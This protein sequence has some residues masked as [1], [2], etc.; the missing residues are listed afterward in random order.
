MTCEMNPTEIRNGHLR[1][2][3]SLD[4]SSFELHCGIAFWFILVIGEVKYHLYVKRQT[5]IC[6]T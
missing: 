4:L 2:C 1:L 6:T 3:V 5:R